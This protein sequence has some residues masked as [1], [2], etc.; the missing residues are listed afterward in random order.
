MHERVD[1]NADGYADVIVS[2]PERHEIRTYLGVRGGPQSP[3]VLTDPSLSDGGWAPV[4][5]GD[6]NGD[7]RSDIALRGAAGFWRVYFGDALGFATERSTDVPDGGGDA[8]SQARALA[9]AGDVDGDGLCDIAHA[10][11]SRDRSPSTWAVITGSAAALSPDDALRGT[12]MILS[13]IGAFGDVDVDGRDD[14]GAV[15]YSSPTATMQSLLALQGADGS[16]GWRVVLDANVFNAD[17]AALRGRVDL[18]GDGVDDAIVGSASVPDRLTAVYVTPGVMMPS[19]TVHRVPN[20]T[21]GEYGLPDVNGDGFADLVV[22]AANSGQVAIFAGSRSGIATEVT[23]RVGLPT[24][25]RPTQLGSPGDIDGDGHGDAVVLS[26]SGT[27]ALLYFVAG[28][29]SLPPVAR[30]RAFDTVTTALAN[31]VA[32]LR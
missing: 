25:A 32:L 23:A 4:H 9:P 1:V 7:G 8:G 14:L 15:G 17:A 6:V 3:L 12:S 19:T 5:L 30:E 16:P 24:S 22:A 18:N 26:S 29:G 28:A 10:L 2:V 20:E 27:A 21:I 11:L 31:G 13:A